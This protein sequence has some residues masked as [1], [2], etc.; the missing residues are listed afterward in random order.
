[1]AYL[2]S[3]PDPSDKTAAALTSGYRVDAAPTASLFAAM[4][5]DRY[6]KEQQY[7]DMLDRAGKAVG[8]YKNQQDAGA[9]A[10]YIQAHAPFVNS[11]DATALSGL[12]PETRL[13]ALTWMQQQNDAEDKDAQTQALNDAKTNYYNNRAIPR[14]RAVPFAP[15][16]KPPTAGQALTQQRYEETQAQKDLNRKIAELN[17]A[18]GFGEHGGPITRAT[19][20]SDSQVHE[21]EGPGGEYVPEGFYAIGSGQQGFKTLVPSD[22]FKQAHSALDAYNALLD[23]NRSAPAQSGAPTAGS[24]Y[25]VG[26]RAKQNGVMYEFDGSAWNPVQ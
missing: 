2:W 9:L 13:K 19:L 3:N 23:K 22:Q 12:P 24:D 21:G 7:Q 20:G 1:M 15:G 16:T 25:P 6:R 5:Q 8:D 10:D 17:L 4:L 26:T 14:P 11:D 18:G